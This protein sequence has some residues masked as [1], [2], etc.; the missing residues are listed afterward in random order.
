MDLVQGRERLGDPDLASRLEWLVTNGIGGYAAGT[1]SGA[2]TRR[3]HGLLIAA[4]DPPNGRR[5]L[6]AKL[7][8]RLIRDGGRVDLDTNRWRSGA[9]HPRGHIHLESFRLEATIPTWTW[10]LGDLRLEKRI[11]MEPGENTTFVEYRL[12]AGQAP[13]ALELDAL[14]NHREP[15]ALAGA[16]GEGRIEPATAGLRI[17]MKEGE[18]PLW[19]TAPGAEIE[20]AAVWHREFA[21]PRERE[22]GLADVEDHLC[23]GTFR[24]RLQP[25]ASFTFVA[26]T[27][28]DAGLGGAGPLALA[29][30]RSRRTAVERE[31]LRSWEKAAPKVAAR[32]PEWVRALVLAADSFLVER[33][34][35]GGRGV[36][37]GYPWLGE[38]GRDALISIPG[39]TLPTG[40][41]EVARTLIAAL[42]VDE[43]RGL[44][45]DHFPESGA[46]PVYGA[47]D[48]ALW[49]FQ[50]VRACDAFAP[51]DEWLGRLYPVLE[52]IGAWYERGTR[53]GIGV[54]P[55][56]G[57]LRVGEDDIA[58]TWMNA[59]ADGAPVTPRRGKPVEINALWY[60]ALTTM[61]RFAR[62][63]GR[64]PDA[65]EQLA[66]R[67]ARSFDRYWNEDAGCLYDLIDGPIGPDSTLRPNQ[68]LAVSLPD[69]PLAAAR[70]KAVL[71][72]C[73]R[74]LLT[75]HGMRS[76]APSDPAYHGRYEGSE[77][78][79]A[80]ALHRGTAWVWL[81]PHLAVAHE[82][83]HRD[84][85]AAL[86]RLE[87]LGR[88]MGST[89][90]GF[91]P[92]L[93]DG[94]PP[95]MPRGCVAHACAVAETLRVWHM[96]AKPA[97]ARTR[98][99][100]AVEKALT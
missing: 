17:E 29:A 31:L 11:W 5:L 28:R 61:A 95:H 22:R 12:V 64:A 63:L 89:A 94:D 92:E 62:R 55:R 75:S 100:A 74:L 96:L 72:T 43:D 37:A 69:S 41:P 15:R 51:D 98:T 82:R 49:L 2:L 90:L 56:D 48:P 45:P 8:E 52:N 73:E 70:R 53:F 9:I 77:S 6:L 71:E 68:I 78:A 83:T 88:L 66:D 3:F 47:V 87:P 65:Y 85:A 21:L 84:R 33:R 36:L 13:I 25:G 34:D 97:P 44:L 50:A 76:L 26:S 40:R 60:N 20:P 46:P 86:A 19:L 99:R 58:Q 14:V 18:A 67:V 80:S 4:L 1:V 32:A 30:A 16:R 54:D 91:L 10:V 57:L 81:L 7:G 39:L 59:L 93:A 24:V 23:A 42:A 35:L 38:A 79:R 27:R